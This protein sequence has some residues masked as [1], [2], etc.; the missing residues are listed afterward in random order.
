M[1]AKDSPLRRLPHGLSAKQIVFFDA[2]R[3][4]AEIAGQAYDDLL[5]ELNVLCT[6]PDPSRPRNFVV[7]VRHAWTF[8]D[9]VHRFRSVLQQAPGIKHNHVYELFM[10]RTASLTEMRNTAQHLNHH[11][12]SIA[13]R[14]QGAYG[15]LKWVVGKG[16]GDVPRPMMLNIGAAYGRVLSPVIDLEERL[17]EDGV[18]RIQL[19]LADRLLTLSDVQDHLTSIVRSL[20]GPLAEFAEGKQ[21]YGSDQFVK[22]ELSPVQPA[23]PPGVN[24]APD[25]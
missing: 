12:A 7:V 2:L 15:T 8:V 1:L 20:E 18:H 9:A 23:A 3:V 25:G 5:S 24:S 4:S 22:F 14:S 17:P 19:E 11:L 10:R 6:E 21:R 16:E 13:E